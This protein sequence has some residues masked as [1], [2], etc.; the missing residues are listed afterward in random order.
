MSPVA[1]RILVV[2]KPCA[3]TAAT[4][5]RLALQGWAA[6]LAE[7]VVKANAMLDTVQ[8]DVVLAEENLPDGRGYDLAESVVQ[9]AATLLVSVALSESC[10]WLPVVERGERSLGRRALNPQ[11]LE[12]ELE[13]LLSGAH[14][15]AAPANAKREIPPRRR[16]ISSVASSSA[17][18]MADVAAPLV[19][20]TGKG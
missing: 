20:A 7:D 6:Q 12:C 17:P 1:L 9:R 5:S 8:V 19:A 2:G 15:D 18:P 11:M 16:N 10:L 14:R 13:M 3:S 4:L